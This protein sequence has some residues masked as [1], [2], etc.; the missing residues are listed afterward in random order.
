MEKMKIKVC[1]SFSH[2][3]NF[4][5]FYCCC[6]LSNLNCLP[7]TCLKGYNSSSNNSHCIWQ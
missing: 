5:L 4:I 1:L 3:F 2:F 7:P 6:C